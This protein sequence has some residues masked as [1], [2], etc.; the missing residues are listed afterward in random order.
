[1]FNKIDDLKLIHC[2]NP[3]YPRES[4]TLGFKCRIGNKE[5]GYSFREVDYSL[6]LTEPITNKRIIGFLEKAIMIIEGLD[7]EN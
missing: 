4:Y 6:S 1:M 3:E 5:Y 7:H 2:K